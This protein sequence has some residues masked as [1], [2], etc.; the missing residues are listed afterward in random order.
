MDLHKKADIFLIITVG[1]LSVTGASI[2]ETNK[3]ANAYI[4]GNNIDVTNKLLGLLRETEYFFFAGDN[5]S[6]ED[7]CRKEM[8]KYLHQKGHFENGT[9][10]NLDCWETVECDIEEVEWK[11]TYTLRAV[12]KHSLLSFYRKLPKA[13]LLP[14]DGHNRISYTF[15]PYVP[16]TNSIFVTSMLSGCSVFVATAGNENCNIIVM[17]ANRF[18]SRYE[19]DDDDDNHKQAMFVLERVN[20]L[21]EQC[22]YQIQRRWSSDLKSSNIERHYQVVNYSSNFG[23]FIYGYNLGCQHNWQFCVKELRP[24]SEPPICHTII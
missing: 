13:I 20:P 9:T 18:C 21:N 4:E 2:C 19:P 15:L 8:D 23:N 14:I 1:L 7:G 3:D 11:G 24:R 17:H 6:H 12:Q 10:W 5:I 22:N 16:R